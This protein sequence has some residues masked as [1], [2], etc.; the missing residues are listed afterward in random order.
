VNSLDMKRD[1]EEILV[2]QARNQ[3]VIKSLQCSRAHLLRKRLI[4]IRIWQSRNAHNL[5]RALP[6][7]R[8]LVNSRLA[9]CVSVNEVSTHGHRNFLGRLSTPRGLGGNLALEIA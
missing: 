7:V 6:I 8:L 2:D 9:V 3:F 4:V 1:R 5:T